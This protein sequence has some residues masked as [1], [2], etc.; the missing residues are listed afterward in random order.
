MPEPTHQP[1]VVE[2]AVVVYPVGELLAGIRGDMV[3]SFARVEKGLEAKA[4]KADFARLDGRLDEHQKAIAEL[5]KH[6]GDDDVSQSIRAVAKAARIDW[7]RWLYPTIATVAFA[8]TSIL[9]LTGVLG[10]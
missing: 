10:R 8:L 3:A 9:Q 2:G 7:H 1:R 6:Q 4:D 5:R